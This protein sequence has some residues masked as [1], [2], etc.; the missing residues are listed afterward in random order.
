[1]AVEPHV[2]GHG[3][4]CTMGSAHTVVAKDMRRNRHEICEGSIALWTKH[5][6]IL[7]YPIA[8]KACFQD[9]TTSCAKASRERRTTTRTDGNPLLSCKVEA[10]LSFSSLMGTDR[11]ICFLLEKTAGITFCCD[12]HRLLECLSHTCRRETPSVLDVLRTGNAIKQVLPIHGSLRVIFQ[13]PEIR[14][15][16]GAR[17]AIR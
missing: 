17:G 3:D 14:L 6:T 2:L 5:F 16:Q 10:F 13:I 11:L 12:Q 7:R 1:M 15:P 4:A 9:V 8:D